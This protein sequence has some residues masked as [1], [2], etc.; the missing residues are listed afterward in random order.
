MKTKFYH[1]YADA[2]DSQGE[3]HTV[4]IV[5]K[6][7]QEYI[8][9]P[10]TENASVEIKPSH[11]VKG[12]LTFNRKTLHRSL[13]IG[14]AICNPSDEFNEEEG[15]RVAKSRIKRGDNLGIIETNSATMLTEDLILAEM[16]GKLTYVTSHIDKYLGPKNNS[17]NIDSDPIGI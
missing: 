16:L 9:K 8:Q 1:L 5:G 6:F 4:T 14:L 17:F 7:V 15:V 12:T 10:I 2:V 11:F 13:T 3:E